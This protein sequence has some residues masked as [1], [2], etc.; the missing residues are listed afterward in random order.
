MG[1]SA[2]GAGVCATTRCRR[3]L[4]VTS[5]ENNVV[6]LRAGLDRRYA[7]QVLDADLESNRKLSQRVQA[8]ATNA[9][10]QSPDP[11]KTQAGPLRELRL[12]QTFD[13]PSLLQPGAEVI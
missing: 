12:R 13:F 8:G 9:L 1:Q 3:S 10:F 7:G 2:V 11:I 4:A 6:R 5:A